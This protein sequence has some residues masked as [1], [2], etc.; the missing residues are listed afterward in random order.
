MEQYLRYPSNV[1]RANGIVREIEQAGLVD[2]NGQLCTS[3]NWLGEEFVISSTGLTITNL[4][5]APERV[6]MM[7]I[8]AVSP[9]FAA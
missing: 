6:Q 3:P 2:W 5:R 9:E 4:H 7:R 1:T 8:A